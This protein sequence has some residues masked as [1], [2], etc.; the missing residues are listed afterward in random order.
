MYRK[1]LSGVLIILFILGVL[2][3]VN[4]IAQNKINV[5]NKIA[6]FR[7]QAVWLANADG[8]DEKKL[9]NDTLKVNDFL[10]STSLRYLACTIVVGSEMDW[11]LVDSTET[12]GQREVYSIIV[13]D[14]VTNRIVKKIDYSDI[15]FERWLAHN[16]LLY[17]T[18]SAG[19]IDGFYTYDPVKNLVIEIPDGS[20]ASEYDFSSD[21]HLVA[22]PDT[23]GRNLHLHF[24]DINKDT[25]LVSG[26]HSIL[27]VRISNNAKYISFLDVEPG[28]KYKYFDNL[29][30]YNR[31]N[32]SC[33]LLNKS[34]AHPK[35]GSHKYCVWSPDDRYIGMFFPPKAIVVEVEN[36]SEIIPIGGNNFSW[37]PNDIV[38]VTLNYNAYVFDLKTKSSKLLIKNA[39][40]AVYLR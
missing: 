28:E 40:K 22:Y 23:Y 3:Q 32:S 18:A 35:S 26:K 24:M 37:M 20:R 11:G 19:G 29:W 39:Y 34:P 12:P 17:I 38:L 2:L 5:A 31:V 25:V 16:R 9:T 36:P 30:L 8:T 21:G 1:S 6:F 33:I 15:H 7:D 4:T 13:L 10:F 14:L 27:E